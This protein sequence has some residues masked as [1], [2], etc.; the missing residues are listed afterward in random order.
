MMAL[1]YILTQNGQPLK[2]ASALILATVAWQKISGRK[3]SASFAVWVP[4]IAYLSG[5][6]AHFGLL[7]SLVKCFETYPVNNFFAQGS[8]QLPI[9]ASNLALLQLNQLSLAF[10]VRHLLLYHVRL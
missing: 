2:L 7:G 9:V 4:C 10:M 6:L 1:G 8:L 3:G 5:C